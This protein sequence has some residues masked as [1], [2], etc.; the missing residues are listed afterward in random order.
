MLRNVL[1]SSI[2][3]AGGLIVSSIFFIKQTDADS[4]VVTTSIVVTVCG[5]SIVETG[6]QCDDGNAVSGD[7]CSSSCQDEGPV[8]GNSVVETGEQCDD[9]NG[10]SGDG[11]SATCQTEAAPP[12]GGGGGGPAIQPEIPTSVVLKGKAYPDSLI[13]VLKDG[14]IVKSEIANAEAD[15]EI[16]ITGITEGVYTFGLWA[17]TGSGEKSLTF[18]FTTLILKNTRTTIGGIFL[19]PIISID[20]TNVVRGDAVTFLG[21]TAP[22]STIDIHVSSA[23]EIIRQTTADSGGLWSYIFD[24]QPLEEGTHSGKAKSSSPEGLLSGFSRIVN[25]SVGTTREEDGICQF[26]DLNNDGRVD[27]VDFSIM[28]FHWNGADECADLNNDG[29]VSI[30]DFSILLYWWTG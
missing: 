2:V 8:C 25:F 21:Q 20:R 3:I 14:V 16:E 9:G 30:I 1:L 15:F 6:E 10:L 27:L 19:A 13:T 12:S 29:S 24:T 4:V 28:M 23:H 7:G 18:S 26:G 22:S 5:N 11:C 17:G